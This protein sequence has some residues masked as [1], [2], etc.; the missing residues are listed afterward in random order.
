MNENMHYLRNYVTGHFQHKIWIPDIIYLLDALLI[1]D[2]LLFISHESEYIFTMNV[3]LIPI[4]KDNMGSWN[5]V[6]GLSQTQN[7]DERGRSGILMK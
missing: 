6:T 2:L 3:H 4:L 1:S 5:E 7:T